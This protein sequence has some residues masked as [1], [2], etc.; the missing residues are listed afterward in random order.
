MKKVDITYIFETIRDE[1]FTTVE[2]LF[3]ASENLSTIFHDMSHDKYP[4]SFEI[5]EA[6]ILG[7]FWTLKIIANRDLGDINEIQSEFIRELAGLCSTAEI[8]LKIYD[9]NEFRSFFNNRFS[10]YI[11]ELKK[12]NSQGYDFRPFIEKLYIS[13]LSSSKS[14]I[15]YEISS[16]HLI[17]F[18]TFPIKLHYYNESMNQI[19]DAI[20]FK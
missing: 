5:L 11:A 10:L 19:I 4:N 16:E 8:M 15:D 6:K 9:S 12:I 14:S 20:D 2:K 13:P 1:K 17:H 3:L 18:T 7:C